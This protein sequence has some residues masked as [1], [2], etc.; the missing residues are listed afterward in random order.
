MVGITTG[1]SCVKL[2]IDGQNIGEDCHG[3]AN[4]ESGD[5]YYIGRERLSGEYQR[6]YIGFISQFSIYNRVLS[7][8]EI[9]DIYNA[10]I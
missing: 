10:N 3:D 7:E 5:D 1:T 4:Y 8:N 6:G 9:L 2:Y